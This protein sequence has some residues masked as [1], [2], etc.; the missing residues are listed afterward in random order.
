[1]SALGDYNAFLK[2]KEN[3]LKSDTPSARDILEQGVQAMA[4]RAS[5]RDKPD[6]ERSMGLAVRTFNALKGTQLTERDGWQFMEILKMARAEQGRF[7][8]DDYVDGAA[9]CALAGEAAAKEAK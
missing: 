5:L 6:G 3:S 1:M 4:D 9:Y 7:S 8:Q 2:M